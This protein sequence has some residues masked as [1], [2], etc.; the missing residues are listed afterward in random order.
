MPWDK[1]S[2]GLEDVLSFVDVLGE[3]FT[4]VGDLSVHIIDEE[5]LSEIVLVVGIWH[6]LVVKGHG[7]T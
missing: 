1:D 2:L 6:S 4:F 5:W 7:G 3:D